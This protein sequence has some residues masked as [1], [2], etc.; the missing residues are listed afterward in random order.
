MQAAKADTKA[1]AGLLPDSWTKVKLER[2]DDVNY[3]TVHL[4]FGLES[5]EHTTNLNV[6]SCLVVRA[7]IGEKKENGSPEYV[8]R[9]YTP[10]SEPNAK[11]G[12]PFV[13]AP[14][15]HI[16]L[17]CIHHLLF[18]SISTTSAL[19]QPARVSC[20]GCSSRRRRALSCA[21]RKRKRF[22]H[23]RYLRRAH[24]RNAQALL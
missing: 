16:V 5:P 17:S 4:R 13:G 3:N 12:L 24:R 6:A 14:S 10:V 7:P 1:P 11:C 9:P 18:S 22:T 21:R 23:A 8:I 19:L 20:S 15:V 2:K